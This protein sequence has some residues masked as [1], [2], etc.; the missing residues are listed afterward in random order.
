MR[1]AVR[2]CA[3]AL[4]L[5]LCGCSADRASTRHTGGNNAA[6]GAAGQD[7]GGSS[8]NTNTDGGG[9]SN[10][11][12]NAGQGGQA[13]G[14]GVVPMDGGACASVRVQGKRDVHPGN[15]LVVF[16]QSLTMGDL[17][18]DTNGKAAAK[19]LVASMALTTAVQGVMGQVN[20]GAIF[21]PTTA[22]TDIPACTATV[23]PITMAPQIA[24]SPGAAFLP[25]WQQHFAGASPL[26]FGTPLN[27]A[28]KAAD[29]AL[30]T[31]PSG[32]TVLVIFTDGQWTCE[33]GSEP[34]TVAAL[35]SR[36]IKT[37]VV[38]LPGA[39]GATG[40]DK[41][42]Q[43]GGTAAMGCTS[44]CFLVPTDAAKLQA[45]ISMIAAQTVGFDTCSFTISG[46]IV[47]QKRACSTG[48]VKIDGN[49][50]PCDANNGF[51]VDDATHLSF[52]GSACDK[53]KSSGTALEATFPCDVVVVQ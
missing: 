23:A 33:D 14:T 47:D 22:A 51:G 19:Y 1:G 28:L 11:N 48:M 39:L 36:G 46:K 17:W 7:A 49:M 27:K 15:M 35:L 50:V 20:A 42:A 52:H 13:G 9:F 44:N 18:T 6:G 24:L 30:T 21:F 38:G 4:M 45:A 29:T 37:Y 3:T 31:A 8:A 41:L 40:L 32:T 12:A 2:C 53:L 16:D 34:T 26:I 43:A 10:G 25:M 5:V